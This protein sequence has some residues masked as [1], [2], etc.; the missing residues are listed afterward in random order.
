MCYI[1]LGGV[2]SRFALRRD[3][4]I[5]TNMDRANSGHTAIANPEGRNFEREERRGTAR[6]QSV[7][8]A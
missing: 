4:V 6:S 7:G 2:A 3:P 1:V 8:A 5:Q